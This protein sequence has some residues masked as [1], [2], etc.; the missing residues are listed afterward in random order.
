MDSLI[1][2]PCFPSTIFFVHL[3]FPTEQGTVT[4]G[5]FKQ[6][7]AVNLDRKNILTINRH[8]S[9]TFLCLIIQPNFKM[10]LDI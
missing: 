6:F 4:T 8:K 10:V 1:F 3:S 9:I 7:F 5:I 2:K